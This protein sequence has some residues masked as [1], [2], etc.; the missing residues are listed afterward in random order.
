MKQSDIWKK[1]PA[2]L[3]SELKAEARSWLLPMQ[4]SRETTA[5]ANAGRSGTRAEATQELRKSKK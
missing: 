4:A 5:T 3:A 1:R 2:G